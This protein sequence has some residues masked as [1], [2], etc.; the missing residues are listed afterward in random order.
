M[1]YPHDSNSVSVG[2]SAEPPAPQVQVQTA[3]TEEQIA[4]CQKWLGEEHYLG[5][6]R[7]AGERLFQIVYEDGQP[8]AVLAWAASAWHLKDRDEWI[9]WDPLTRACRLKLIVSNWRFLVFEAA[10]RPNLAS[11]C[12]GAAL[13]AL[14]GQW[15]EIHGYRPLL[16][17]TFTDPE[18]HAGTIY[19][20]TNWIPLGFSKGFSRHYDDYYVPNDRPKKLWVYELHSEPGKARQLLCARTLPPE[21]AEGETDGAGV[22]SVLKADQLRSLAQVFREI[23][24]PR[25]RAGMRYPLPAVL[26]IVALA[27]LGGAVHISEICRAGQRLSQK[28]RLQIGLRRKRGTQF[29]AAPGYHV[30]R[31][32][33]LKLDHAEMERVF[34]QWLGENQGILPRSLALD[35]KTIAHKLG[36]TVSI[37][38]QSDG[39]PV[40]IACTDEG[41]E[42]P[43]SQQLLGSGQVQLINTIITADAL[44]CQHDTAREIVT[45]GGDYLLRVR[46]NQ[47][48]LHKHVKALLDPF[49]PDTPP[50]F[51]QLPRKATGA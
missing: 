5:P 38:D 36:Q 20:A 35:G 39:V 3:T 28:Q 15:Q 33:L 37:V 50:L 8:V 11:Q 46:G 44:H 25:A 18:S 51:R 42:L 2:T 45:G 43:A 24:D 22:R 12:L 4:Q 6:A 30:Y 47:P 7:T 23:P 27:L 48:T 16:A 29:F 26:T 49:D 21:H 40:A 13:R 1:N 14:P 17:E 10:R 31:D 41:S 32:L 9:D 34:N 19:K